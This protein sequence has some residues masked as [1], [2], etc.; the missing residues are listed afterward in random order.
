MSR[1]IYETI[2]PRFVVEEE[3]VERTP[4]AREIYWS[5]CRGFDT[6]EEAVEEADYLS[7]VNPSTNYRVVDTQD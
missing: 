1:V 4:H 7:L 5:P 2:T 6:R 3:V